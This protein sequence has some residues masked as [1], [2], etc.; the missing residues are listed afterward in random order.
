MVVSG[1][2]ILTK[3]MKEVIEK[4]IKDE[5]DDCE[6]RI[7]ALDARSKP[8][9]VDARGE[10]LLSSQG[11]SDHS[12]GSEEGHVSKY[13]EDLR[14]AR[15]YA[16][17]L[18]KLDPSRKKFEMRLYSIMPTT[19]FVLVDDFLYVTFLLSEPVERCPMFRINRTANPDVFRTFASHFDHYWDTAKSFST[20]IALDEAGHSMFVKGPDRAWEWPTGYV[21]ASAEQSAA[22]AADDFFERMTGYQIDDVRL[23]EQTIS[24]SFYVGRLGP[25][26][27]EPAESIEAV[28][29]VEELP[30]HLQYESDRKYYEELIDDAL[31]TIESSATD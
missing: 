31:E 4:K 22:E 29:L 7:L 3:T 20:V 18:G 12:K 11:V 13:E 19:F 2:H 25:K 9:F 5:N 15:V 14:G 1:R 6:I 30:E 24:G 17:K 23:L 27:G 10:M 16:R 8:E 26:L 28:D 21:E